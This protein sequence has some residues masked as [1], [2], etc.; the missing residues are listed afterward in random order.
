[1]KKTIQKR[2]DQL[3]PCDVVVIFQ[4]PVP[5][6]YKPGERPDPPFVQSRLVVLRR[7]PPAPGVGLEYALFEVDCGNSLGAVP[8]ACTRRTFNPEQLLDVEAPNLTPAQVHAD[9][10]VN[11][12]A[13]YLFAAENK[14]VPA[15]SE[16]EYAELRDLVAELKPPEPVTVA[17]ALRALRDLADASPLRDELNGERPVVRRA[18]DLLERDRRAGQ[19]P[20]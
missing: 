17:E 10:L 20:K 18:L 11:F 15:L 1:M 4:P 8:S 14:Y 19:V 16:G 5:R 12:A 13:D 6:M 2:A 3:E 7:A 9:R